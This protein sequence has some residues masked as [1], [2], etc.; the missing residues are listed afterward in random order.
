L[1]LI[2]PELTY[3]WLFSVISQRLER[4]EAI[5]LADLR[6]AI[7]CFLQFSGIDY[8]LDAD[9]GARLDAYTRWVQSVLEHYEGYLAQLTMGDKGNCMY[10]LFGAPL[11]HEDDARRAMG[12]AMALLKPPRELNFIRNIRI[13]ISQGQMYIG[14]Y[15]GPTR[16]TYGGIGREVN[17]AARLMEQ[18]RPGQILVSER[19]AKAVPDYNFES[20]GALPFKGISQPVPVFAISVE[21]A[22]HTTTA[23][24]AHLRSSLPV[25]GRPQEQALLYDSLEELKAGQSRCC[26]IVGEAGI[27]K[28]RLID[29]L[30][31]HTE[32]MGLTFLLGA[33]DAMEATTAYYAWRQIF[34]ALFGLQETDGMDSLSSR[35]GLQHLILDLVEEDD[36]LVERLPL[37]NAVLPLGLPESALTAQMSGELR[38]QNTRDTLVRLLQRIRLDENGLV[39]ILEDAHW[40]DSASWALLA[41]VQQHIQ[42]LFWWWGCVRWRSRCLKN[43]WLCGRRRGRPIWN[44]NP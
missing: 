43:M 32:A 35:R 11:S 12:A 25:V 33:G 9:A 5:S 39:L 2:A 20:L 8:D 26:L 31:E 6:N 36:Y 24:F 13:G 40:L 42:P 44:C 28:T 15:G 21:G 3:P 38:A 14:T 37:L 7:P 30:C 4:E 16:R 18:A 1:P 10:I 41:S 27:G 22:I 17:L 19:I 29:D 23:R 34:R